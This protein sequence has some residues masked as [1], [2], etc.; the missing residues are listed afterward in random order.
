M[1]PKPVK[2]L[3]D[4]DI[5]FVQDKDGFR[6]RVKSIC[7]KCE[8]YPKCIAS[9]TDRIMGEVLHSINELNIF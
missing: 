9:K 3:A 2:H 6:T 5:C 7:K 1:K 8:A 4:C